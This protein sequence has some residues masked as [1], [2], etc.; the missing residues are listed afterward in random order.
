MAVPRVSWSAL[1]AQRRWLA[2]PRSMRS[3]SGNSDPVPLVMEGPR[4]DAD[5]QRKEALR[6]YR[7][8]LRSARHFT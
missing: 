5:L 2:V 7:D 6:L 4:P 1:T 8:I 3:F